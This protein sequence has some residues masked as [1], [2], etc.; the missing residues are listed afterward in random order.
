MSADYFSVAEFRDFAGEKGGRDYVDTE[1]IR[2]QGAVIG[3]LEAWAHSAWPN[4][5]GADGD[6]TAAEPRSVQEMLDGGHDSV[7][8]DRLPVLSVELLTFNDN[9][10]EVG[11]D[12]W[13]YVDSGIIRFAGELEQTRQTLQVLYRYGFESCP[14]EVKLPVM[15]ATQSRMDPQQGRKKL[16]RNAT[17]ISSR[18]TIATLTT[19][20]DESLP[21]SWDEEASRMMQDY[22]G[23]SRKRV[24]SAAGR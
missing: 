5:T 14:D 1:I 21:W 13:L 20:S 10:L 22:W 8:L 24:F 6:G 3:M 19:G 7:V 18:G 23:G 17:Q 2:N 11:T 9:Q 16:P 15:H 4:V 12:Y